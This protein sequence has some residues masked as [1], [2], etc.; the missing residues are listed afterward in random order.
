V[1]NAILMLDRPQ[2]GRL[3]NRAA[4]AVL[5]YDV[6]QLAT[7]LY[8]TGG[9]QNPFA[10]LMVAPVAVAAASLSRAVT[11]ALGA[12]ALFLATLLA[13]W[14]Q[15]LPW[16]AP[17]LELPMPFRVGVWIAV[18]MTIGFVAAYVHVFHF[19]AALFE[20]VLKGWAVLYPR[21]QL[22]PH[23][24]GLQVATLG[25]PPGC[26]A[27]AYGRALYADLRRLDARGVDRLLVEE[28]PATP[29]WE[30]VRDRLA[31]AAATFR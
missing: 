23:I 19:A 6:M 9:L 4:G 3:D 26:D 18:A 13:F 1:L 28:A 7:L 2:A 5:A 30:A 15:P 16:S 14:H 25:C 10:V 21:F 11:V 12:L 29:E 17:G 27:A 20:P 22:T 31:R 8:F 24:D